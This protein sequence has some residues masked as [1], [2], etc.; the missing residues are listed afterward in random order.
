[1]RTSD[2]KEKG[3]GAVPDLEQANM[4]MSRR[5]SI[6]NSTIETSN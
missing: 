1:M 3:S 5:R 6:V 2:S 4:E